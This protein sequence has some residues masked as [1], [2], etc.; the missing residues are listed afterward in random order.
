[1]VLPESAKPLKPLALE[2]LKATVVEERGGDAAAR[3][4]LGSALDS[5][6]AE[7]RNFFKSTSEGCGGDTPSPV[8]FVDEEAGDSPVRQ[9]AESLSVDT[10]MLDSR[11]FIR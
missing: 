4:I 10:Q 8:G 5:A 9:L 2:H 7:A 1:M 11:Q 3:Y 6:T